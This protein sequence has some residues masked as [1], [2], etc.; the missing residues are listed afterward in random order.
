MLLL[1]NYVLL[2][3]STWYSK[4]VEES[5]SILRINNIQCITLVIIV[6]SYF[7]YTNY[8]HLTSQYGCCGEEENLFLLGTKQWFLSC[9]AH[10]I[11]TLQT[12]LFMSL[13][14]IHIFPH[15]TCFSSKMV[16]I[17]SEVTEML[18]FI[19]CESKNMT[20]ERASLGCARLS[21]RSIS[22]LVKKVQS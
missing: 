1:Y 6:W 10:S 22:F 14:N 11:V 20:E 7:G 5:N 8:Y 9:L 12:T 3:M 18:I 19:I 13:H 21:Y 2:K 15:K 16:E 17:N 4:H